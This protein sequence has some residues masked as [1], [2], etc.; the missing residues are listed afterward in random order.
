MGGSN[1]VGL[2]LKTWVGYTI[3][4]MAPISDSVIRAYS[5]VSS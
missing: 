5:D 2:S 4:R 3:V 1:D